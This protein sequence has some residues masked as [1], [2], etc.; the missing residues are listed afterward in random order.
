MSGGIISSELSIASGAV[1]DIAGGRLGNFFTASKGS[2]VTL[3]GNNFKLDGEAFI[4]NAITI[5]SETNLEALF[6]GTFS[7]GSPFVFKANSLVNGRDIL[8]GVTLVRQTL[9]TYDLTPQTIHQAST[10]GGLRS[11]QSLTLVIGGELGGGFVTQDAK[12]TVAGGQLGSNLEAVGT[13]VVMTHGSIGIN[14]DLMKGSTLTMSGGDIESFF[15]AH[16]DT[17]IDLSGGS[18]G[19]GMRAGS[20]SV[21]DMT[22]GQIDAELTLRDGATL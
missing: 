19:Y 14:S 9:P 22:G 18:I 21:I 12:L 5:N 2:Q 15:E 6:T 7:D 17:R 4:H 20:G 8:E 3:Y 10:L 16:H 13:E 1:A 11:G